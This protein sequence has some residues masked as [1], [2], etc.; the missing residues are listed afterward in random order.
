MQRATNHHLSISAFVLAIAGAGLFLAGCASQPSDSDGDGKDT[1][2][3]EQDQTVPASTAATCEPPGSWRLTCVAPICGSTGFSAICRT[4]K[5]EPKTTGVEWGCPSGT[6]S[7]CN[8]TL[9]CD[10]YS[11][12]P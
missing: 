8:G 4:L 9:R 7:N 10:P 6:Y 12:C 11:P 1:S 3:V 5:G 2:L